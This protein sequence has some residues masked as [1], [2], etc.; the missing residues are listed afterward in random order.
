MFAPSA[1]TV[2]THF[3][4]GAGVR[5]V[6]SHGPLFDGYT[7]K[8]NDMKNPIIRHK[9]TADPTVLVHGEKAY[10]F[11]GHDVPP[12]G[13]EDYVMRDWLCFSSGDLRTWREHPVPLKAADFAWAG[14]D[15]FAS[16]VVFREG[17]FYWYVALTHR[18]IPGKAIG[19]AVSRTPEGPYTDALGGPLISG[20]M[21]MALTSDKEN[22]DPTVLIDDDGQAYICWGYQVCHFAKL[23][24]S[25]TKLAGEISTIPLPDFSEGSHL[26]KRNG[27]YYLMYGQGMPEKVGYAMSS[28]INGPWEYRGIVNEIPYNCETNRPATLDFQGK[29]WFFYH[30]GA[31]RGG[32]S[33]RRSVCMDSLEY[34]EDGSVREV[35][36]S[37]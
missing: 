30:N 3:D 1:I 27:H 32:G 28:S 15:A 8:K 5:P 10:L 2:I 35:G 9:Y 17:W 26:Y 34:E 6:L 29:S 16:K 36:M 22:L 37:K 33:H 14:E 11:T 18:T 7:G 24:D 4:T 19:V 12:Q 21:L 13:V 31:L 23:D 25:M 20:E